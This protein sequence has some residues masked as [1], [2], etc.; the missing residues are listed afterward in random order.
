MFES[1]TI[2]YNIIHYR[3]ESIGYAS[4][5]KSSKAAFSWGFLHL[6]ANRPSGCLWLTSVATNANKAGPEMRRS[7]IHLWEHAQSVSWFSWHNQERQFSTVWDIHC[8]HAATM[9][10]KRRSGKSFCERCFE[11]A[12]EA[13][14]VAVPKS[15][16]NTQY[17][18]W[19]EPKHVATGPLVE[20][21]KVRNYTQTTSGVLK[22][23]CL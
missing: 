23:S 9:Q 6:G 8:F 5:R 3:Y 2:S 10:S 20:R 4:D 17:C 22:I 18:T 1:R 16:L 15:K 21:G 12:I 19:H 14:S 7:Q 11:A 13:I